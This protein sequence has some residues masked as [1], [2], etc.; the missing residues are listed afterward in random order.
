MLLLIK[1]IVIYLLLLED[2]L[3]FILQYLLS[4]FSIGSTHLSMSY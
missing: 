3:K 2:I 4:F 1:D